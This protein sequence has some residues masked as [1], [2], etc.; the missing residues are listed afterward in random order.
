MVPI[1]P[2]QGGRAACLLRL[3]W[4]TLL[5]PRLPPLGTFLLWC[6]DALAPFSGDAEMP[7]FWVPISKGERDP[8]AAWPCTPEP[9]QQGPLAPAA[10]GEEAVRLGKGR[11]GSSLS[12]RPPSLPSGLLL[13]R[14]AGHRIGSR[15]GLLGP[16]TGSSPALPL[17]P[18]QPLPWGVFHVFLAWTGVAWTWAGTTGEKCPFGGE[19]PLRR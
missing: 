17:L 3:G 6:P 2:R 7:S 18:F 9:R 13:R 8:G 11:D 10:C 4:L 5:R 15:C 14:N 12:F 1:S 19:M 16:A